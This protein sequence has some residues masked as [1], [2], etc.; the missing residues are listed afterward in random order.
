MSIHDASYEINCMHGIYKL[1]N[2]KY[3]RFALFFYKSEL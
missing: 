2:R 3:F 1:V